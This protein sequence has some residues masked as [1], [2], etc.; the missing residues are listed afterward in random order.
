MTAFNLDLIRKP[1]R[2]NNLRGKLVP[3]KHPRT[4]KKLKGF[5]TAKEKMRETRKRRRSL[6]AYVEKRPNQLPFADALAMAAALIA[7]LLAATGSYG[8]P[9]FADPRFISEVRRRV[10]GELLRLLCTVPA[11]HIRFYTVA[12]PQWRLPADELGSLNPR[13]LRE[14]LRTNLNRYGKLAELSGWAVVFFHNDYDSTTDSHQ[15]HFHVVVVGKK[16]LAFEALRKLKMFKGGKGSSVYRPIQAQTVGNL[17]R[18][19]SY[20]FKTYVPSKNSYVHVATNGKR[21]PK[22]HYRMPEPR[23]A[24]MMLFYHRLK[25]SDIVWLHGLKIKNRRLRVDN[26]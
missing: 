15:P 16:R 25:F 8:A 5:E 19:V 17:V 11:R 1:S 4:G 22:T 10:C 18:Q 20:L 26:R 3:S 14:S 13:A 2:R 23:H 7:L 9:T 24:E 21:R 12:S 6:N